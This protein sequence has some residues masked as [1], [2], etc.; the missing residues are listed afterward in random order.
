MPDRKSLEQA[1][2]REEALLSRLDK[3]RE[4]ALSR[5]Q[6]YKRDLASLE[7]ACSE[8]QASYPPRSSQ[9]KVE[10]FRSLFR[11]REDIF[12]K[13][14]TSRAGE[15]DYSPACTN[16]WMSG[17]CG[18]TRKPPVKCGECSNRKFLPVTDQVIIDHLQGRHVIGVYPMLPDDTCC[19]L[20]ADFDKD[21]WMDD[22][23]AF[24]ETCK[25]M[26]IPVAVERSRSGNGAH[27]WFFFTELVPA[28]TARTMGC[29][30]ITETMSRRHQLSMESY[31]RLFPS[32]D[33]LT[34]D[35]FG[36]LIALP[37][38]QEPRQKGNTVF[39]DENFTPYKD[40]WVYL[41]SI[42]RLSPEMIQRIANE[43]IRLDSVI[44]VPRDTSQGEDDHAPWNRM[45]SRK[46]LKRKIT[47]MFPSETHGIFAQRLFIEKKIYPHLF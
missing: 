34:K 22:V 25:S 33:T 27:A 1:I 7:S 18:K 44:G 4:Q 21:T 9:E 40:Q 6:D 41:A 17:V 23:R 28:A 29:F 36:N 15:K 35:G 31:D 10:L 39:L 26:G 12:P 38:Q 43:A 46:K 5:I 42:G 11:G 3:V 20:A 24:R 14:W 8:S 16:D 32:Q 2:A 45:P 47:G 19:F 13:L 37:F 30:L